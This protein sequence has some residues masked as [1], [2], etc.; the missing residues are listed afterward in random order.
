MART[1]D[2]ALGVECTASAGTAP[3]ATAHRGAS[4][5][6]NGNFADQSSVHEAVQP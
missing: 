6:P 1:F 2:Y 4:D 3:T 5:E